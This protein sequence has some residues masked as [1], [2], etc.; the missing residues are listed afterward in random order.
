MKLAYAVATPGIESDSVVAFRGPLEASMAKLAE[1]GYHGVELALKRPANIQPSAV[2][3]LCRDFGLEVPVVTTGEIYGEDCLS[4][5]SPDPR[6]RA[7]ALARMKEVIE[8]AGALGAMVNIGRVRGQYEQG[9]PREQTEA[10]A[11]AAFVRLI[12]WAAKAGTVLLL[13]PINRFQCTFITT[14]QEGL[15]WV[16]KMNSERFKMMVDLFHMNIEDRSIA[17]SFTEVDRH[18]KHVHVCDSNRNA[19]GQGH[20]NFAEIIGA[21]KAVG[22]SGYLSGEVLNIPDDETAAR[23]TIK[24]LKRLT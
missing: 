19:P 9:T 21:L 5:S 24:L 17:G 23:L 3:K 13:E 7:R 15:C 16:E 18:L 6:I 22:Y 10:W 8:L 20:L 11:E 2:L 1:M 4:L 14:T 12:G